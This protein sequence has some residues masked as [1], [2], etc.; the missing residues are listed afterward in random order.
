M[1]WQHLWLYQGGYRLVAIQHT[2]A[3]PLGNQTTNTMTRPNWPCNG[4]FLYSKAALYISLYI[5]N[6]FCTGLYTIWLPRLIEPGLVHSAM[7]AV[8]CS[9][10]S[11]RP[12]RRS[13]TWGRVSAIESHFLTRS[14]SSETCTWQRPQSVSCYV[15]A[16]AKLNCLK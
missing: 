12:V 7:V 4:I 15:I 9:W 6:C 1:S 11:F 16:H 2:H 14:Y 3:V 8:P 10:R 5:S 13:T